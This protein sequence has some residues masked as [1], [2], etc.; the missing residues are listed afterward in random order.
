MRDD[1]A[2]VAQAYGENG[3][4]LQGLNQ[5]VPTRPRDVYREITERCYEKARQRGQRT[6]TLVEQDVTSVRLI[7]EWI[8]ENIETAPSGKLHDALAHAIAMR[9]YPSRKN[10]D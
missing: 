3:N 1:E 10:A 8:K 4:P 2:K 5:A 9:D 7:A 6:F